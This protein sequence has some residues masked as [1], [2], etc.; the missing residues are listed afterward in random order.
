MSAPARGILARLFGS[1]LGNG[2][3]ARAAKNMQEKEK[4]RKRA[5]WQKL[6][7]EMQAEAR[8]VES[9]M[10]A[11]LAR[12]GYVWSG[13]LFTPS[14]EN[15]RRRKK[16]IRVRMQYVRWREDG[17]WYKLYVRRRGLFKSHDM[18]P[19]RTTL[20]NLMSKET[21]F[22]LEGALERPVTFYHHPVKGSWFVVHRSETTA[23]LPD[24]VPY[25]SI[26]DYYPGEL[27][28]G[29]GFVVGVGENNTVLTS[30]LHE[31]PHWLIAG[32][33]GSG[34]SNQINL[35]LCQL[36][37]FA[38]P[39]DLKLI[40]IDPK[41]VEFS[42]YENV[43]HLVE[44]IIH[45]I[46]RAVEALNWLMGEIVGRMRKFS[47]LKIKNLLEYN[48]KHPDQKMARI[49]I[50]IEELAM[51]MSPALAGKDAKIAQALMIQ[52]TNTG[53]AAGCHLIA[54]SQTPKAYLM[55]TELKANTARIVGKV[56]SLTASLVILGNGAAAALEDHPGR[57]IY[58]VDSRNQNIQAAYVSN[59]DV[60]RAVAI[61][62]GKAEGLIRYE[63][64][65]V[66]PE[67]DGIIRA[68][69]KHCDGH[70]ALR[71]NMAGYFGERAVTTDQ[72]RAIYQDLIAKKQYLWGD[73]KYV[74]VSS[75]QA[76]ARHRL[77]LAYTPPKMILLPA[78]TGELPPSAGEPDTNEPIRQERARRPA[79]KAQK[80]QLVCVVCGKNFLARADAKTCSQNC[81]KVLQRSKK[82]NA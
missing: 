9:I 75:T 63:G 18:L 77:V 11:T 65:R 79:A 71:A 23:L 10:S 58:T 26:L 35:L 60:A 37:T 17:Y 69:I 20:A 5:L 40:L 73:D 59:D 57:M 66:I 2:G 44:G 6:N 36:I 30:S 51:I 8:L 38:S 74:V 39:A 72:L 12:L 14:D 82:E 68:T 32:S 46:D 50:V 49:V 41:M 45:E 64:L 43:P 24:R 22:E 21:C 1:L 81:R 3:A 54:V 53:R 29:A 19:Y 70:F 78:R 76:E 80:H 47:A 62:R 25:I 55:P 16:A 13:R 67:P 42:F 61:A 48:E 34:K 4:K 52:I 28:G 33:S 56:D 7:R 27:L 15:V 31:Q